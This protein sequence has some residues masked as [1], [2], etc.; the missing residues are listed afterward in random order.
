MR[1]RAI[2]GADFALSA[3]HGTAAFFLRNPGRRFATYRRSALPW[4]MLLLPHSGRNAFFRQN[5]RGFLGHDVAAPF[6]ANCSSS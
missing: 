3:F 6:G 1:N 2:G 5:K 4:A